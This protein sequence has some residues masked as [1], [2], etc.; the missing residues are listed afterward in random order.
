[1]V[2]NFTSEYSWGPGD[3]Y[4]WPQYHAYAREGGLDIFQKLEERIESKL[5]EFSVRLGNMET[6]IASLQSIEHAHLS[7]LSSSSSS[8]SSSGHHKKRSPSDL[9]VCL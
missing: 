5:N 4:N 8:D 9:Q 1:M 3:M 7:S 2:H 6:K